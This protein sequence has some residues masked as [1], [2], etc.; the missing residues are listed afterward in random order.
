MNHTL[1]G[2]E[3]KECSLGVFVIYIFSASLSNVNLGQKWFMTTLPNKFAR[4][5]PLPARNGFE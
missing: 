5:S 3:N 4:T 1:V 2:Q